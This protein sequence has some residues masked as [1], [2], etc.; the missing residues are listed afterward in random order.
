M[1][2]PNSIFQFSSSSSHRVLLT[3]SKNVKTST[4]QQDTIMMTQESYNLN[5]M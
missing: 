4:D 3:S 1:L 5:A 2:K